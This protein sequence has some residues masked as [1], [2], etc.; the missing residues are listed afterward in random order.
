M[1]KGQ[2]IETNYPHSFNSDFRE[3]AIKQEFPWGD[4]VKLPSLKKEFDFDGYEFTIEARPMK[5]WKSSDCKVKK[6]EKALFWLGNI[7]WWAASQV[8]VIDGFRDWSN[9]IPPK[10]NKINIGYWP[11]ATDNG[12]SESDWDC[13]GECAGGPFF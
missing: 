6:G 9:Y 4:D 13:A 11:D 5:A 12:W 3:W 8:E 10:S 2:E 7:P 1:T